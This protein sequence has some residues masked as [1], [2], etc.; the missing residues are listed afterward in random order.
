LLRM[1]GGGSSGPGGSGVSSWGVG[2]RGQLGHGKRD[3]VELPR[4]LSGRIGWGVRIVQ[5][6]AGG[7]LVRVAHSLLLT[8][9]G[10]VLSFGQNSYG[11]LG[12]GYDPGNVL[13]DCLRPRYIDALKNLKCICVSA[14][15]LHSGA[16][17]I[18]GDVYTWGEGFC[19][20]LGL[21]DRRPHLL[22]EQVILGG[23][24][25]ECVS[26]I[27]CGCRHTLVT[28]EEGEV[29]SWGLGRFGVL[30]R[31]YTDFTYQTDVGMVVPDGEEGNVQGAAVRPAADVVAEANQ[32]EG[33]DGLIESLDALNLV[34]DFSLMN[35]L[36][37]FSRFDVP[38]SIHEFQSFNRRLTIQVISA[39]RRSLIP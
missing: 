10:R 21:G 13:S 8:S 26:N 14:G 19:G 2:K 25:D 39:T 38:I 28:T 4:L 7:G 33:I 37:G 18:D 30:G 11:Q 12:H 3:D 1:G 22:P 20:Q 34:S 15:E 35:S 16:V 36:L 31:S 24:D 6:S 17:T 9:T 29:F 32:G 23:L 27:S 5:V